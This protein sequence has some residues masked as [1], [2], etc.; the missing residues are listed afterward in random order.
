MTAVSTAPATVLVVDDDPL[1]RGMARATLEAESLVVD[2]A[3]TGEAAL[4]RLLSDAGGP[5]PRLLLLDLGL[6]GVDGHTVVRKLRESA[7]A[8]RVPIV[9]LTGSEREDDEFALMEEGVDDY[10]RKP[11]DPTRL[12]ARCRAVL[13]RRTMD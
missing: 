7:R 12:R 10:L 1:I 13:R 5:L 9:I 6:P 3:A 11:I 2:E 8:R 4:E